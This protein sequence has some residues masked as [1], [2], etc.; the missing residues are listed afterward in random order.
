MEILMNTL[1][2]GWL[3]VSNIKPILAWTLHK[4]REMLRVV[5]WILGQHNYFFSFQADMK[6][7][8]V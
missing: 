8:I 1:K 4:V 7:H 3:Y 5:K 6:F 2:R